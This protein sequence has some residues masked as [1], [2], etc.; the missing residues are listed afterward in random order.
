MAVDLPIY[1]IVYR[2]KD[3]QKEVNRRIPVWPNP[4]DCFGLFARWNDWHLSTAIN[5]FIDA[6]FERNLR[7]SL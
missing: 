5:Q 2:Q 6:R 3:V 1:Q 7:F 4:S